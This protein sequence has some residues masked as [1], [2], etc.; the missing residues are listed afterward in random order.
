MIRT[1]TQPVKTIEVGRLD[2]VP[3]KPEPVVEAQY[4]QHA[5]KVANTFRS[6]DTG[7]GLLAIFVNYAVIG[8]CIFLSEKDWT[9]QYPNAVKW[10]IYTAA[11]LIIASRLRA[12]ECLVHEA[13]HFN[14][15]KTPSTHY[16]LQFLY[17]F[18][19]LKVLE[20]YRRAHLIHH[21]HLGDPTKDPDLIRIFELGLDKIPEDPVYYLFTLPFSGYVHWEYLSTSFVD[22]WTSR[23]AYPGKAIYWAAVLAGVYFSEKSALLVGLYWAVPFFVVLPVLRYWAEAAEHCG[24]DMNGK[25][26]NSRSNLGL[27]HLWFMHPHNDGYHAVHHLHAQVPFHQ[28]PEAHTALMGENEAF[29]TKTVVSRGFVETF[30]QMATKKTVVKRA[31]N[32]VD[33]RLGKP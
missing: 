14:M 9:N 33:E 25:F 28:L 31:G 10:T 24:M 7:K 22:F 29:R 32:V 20:D 23:A 13:S 2:V 18:P 27:S 19:V 1:K 15:F 3:L 17:A 21:Q 12:F 5:M 8:S 11:C 16:N 30:W 6:R 4:L 26:G